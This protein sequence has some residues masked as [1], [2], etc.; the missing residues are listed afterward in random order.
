MINS[1]QKGARGER[2]F[3]KWIIENLGVSARRGQQFSGGADSP[4]VAC[5]LP[6][7]FEVKRVEKLNIDVAMSQ[8][9]RDCGDN[10]PVVVHRKDGKDWLFTVRA[11]DIE[12]FSRIIDE[13]R[14]KNVGF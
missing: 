3:A 2:E 6:L 5:D 12:E 11:E 4:D 7:H 10:L 1:R 14:R 13:C 9:V 8:A